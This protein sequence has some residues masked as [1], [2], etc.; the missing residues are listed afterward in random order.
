MLPEEVRA[1][2]DQGQQGMQQTY[3]TS[4]LDLAT[5]GVGSFLDEADLSKYALPA[6]LLGMAKAG[7]PRGKVQPE[8]LP[9]YRGVS[10]VS[11]ASGNYYTP[12]RE[13]AREFTQSGL[14]KE[15]AEMAMSKADIYKPKRVP[16][17]GDEAGLSAAIEEARKAGLN[18]LY[19]SEGAKQPHSVFIIDPSKMKKP[20]R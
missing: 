10:S 14:D 3:P 1:L 9:L 20:L 11:P 12:S 17:A 16:F 18:A 8:Q 5:E 2:W 15:I 4:L 19:V 13:F 6:M 7:K